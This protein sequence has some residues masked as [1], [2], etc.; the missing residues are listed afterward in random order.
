MKKY[1]K[2]LFETIIL[3]FGLSTIHANE[4]I[5]NN[6]TLK[7]V[8]EITLDSS[9]DYACDIR[10]S[11][12]EKSISV[13]YGD[14]YI[15]ILDI[16]NGKLSTVIHDDES[17]GDDGI[18]SIA[19]SP[20]GKKTIS[21]TT[22][23]ISIWD[24]KTHKLF[25]RIIIFEAGKANP[26]IT[27]QEFEAEYIPIAEISSL[28]YSP[29]GK[30]IIAYAAN[31][32]M[33][34]NSETGELIKKFIS[35]NYTYINAYCTKY[36]PSGKEIAIQVN[37]E[38]FNVGIYDSKNY[39]LKYKIGTPNESISCIEFSPDGKQIAIGYDYDTI[40]IFDI[41]T[42]KLLHAFGSKNKK[43]IHIQNMLYALNGK[44]LLSVSDNSNILKAWNAQSGKL[45]NSFKIDK[46]NIDQVIYLP[47]KRYIVTTME[48]RIKV[49]K[50]EMLQK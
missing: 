27:P 22:K 33:I 9:L 31:T 13:A 48:N 17:Q 3:L 18:C 38:H 50:I 21:G 23:T 19:F 41:L 4:K 26:I 37:N 44:I 16:E 29:D 30:N 6:I 2:L 32:I 40:K 39:E 15:R 49:W 7:L 46:V 10:Y 35:D 24:N 28:R 1:T 8:K 43:Y 36:S 42:G 12:N 47:N 45:L 25:K 11:P 14:N 20:N 5:D 34:W